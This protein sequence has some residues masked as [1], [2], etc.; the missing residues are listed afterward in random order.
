MNIKENMNIM[1]YEVNK[2]HFNIFIWNFDS[3]KH[4]HICYFMIIIMIL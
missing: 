4:N 2:L 3:I 1:F